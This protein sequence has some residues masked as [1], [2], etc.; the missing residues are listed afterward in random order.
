MLSVGF[1]VSLG[2]AP[3]P[4]NWSSYEALRLEHEHREYAEFLREKPSAFA[5]PPQLISRDPTTPIVQLIIDTDLG[6]DVDDVGAISVA[7]HLQDIGACKIL[8]VIH[9]TGF[10]KGIGGCDVINN[11]YGRTT[12]TGMALG[13]YKGPWGSTTGSQDKYTSMIEQAYPSEIKNF[14]AVDSAVAAYTKTLAK[15]AD[16]SVVIASIGELTNLRDLLMANATLV[17]QKV[18]Q[19]VYMDGSY[20]FGCGDAHGSGTSPWLGSTKGCDGAAKYVNEHMPH[21]VRQLYTLNG[22]DVKTGSRFN[23]NGGNCGHGPVKA[24]YQTWT[25]HGSRPSWD[26]IAVYF[27]V[28]GTSSLYS[29]ERAGT[30]TVNAAGD[31]TFDTSRTDSNEA[32]VWIDSSH[33]GDVTRMLDDVLC[34]SPCGGPSVGAPAGNCAGYTMRAGHNCWDSGHGA[35]DLEN[36]PH[37]ATPGSPMSLYECQK[38]CDETSGCGGVTVVAQPGGLVEC[39]RK[40]NIDIGKCDYGALGAWKFDTWVKK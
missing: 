16:H 35:D 14:D 25:N 6:F 24:A 15:A 39:Y 17:G 26:L 29:S 36:P 32:Q 20:N 22:G 9:N 33:N 23:D 4:A 28:M 18:K 1:A 5:N 31:E 12:E 19:I 34:S 21:T 2:F 38:K 30:N 11:H 40:A 7:N 10:H 8:A 37:S 13:A 27:S 3:P